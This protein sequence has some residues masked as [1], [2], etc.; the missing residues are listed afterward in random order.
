[1]TYPP[2][3]QFTGD[4]AA[5]WIVLIVTGVVVLYCLK[6]I[7]LSREIARIVVES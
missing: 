2:P 6:A 1:M 5:D 4:P 3:I 7:R